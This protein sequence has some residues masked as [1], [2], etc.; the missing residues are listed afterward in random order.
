[1][2]SQHICDRQC[3]KPAIPVASVLNCRPGDGAI[4]AFFADT[5]FAIQS[6]RRTDQTK[7]MQRLHNWD[8]HLA[9]RIMD[10]RRE[11][12]KEIVNV[13]HIRTKASDGMLHQAVGV[14]GVH[15]P[16]RGFHCRCGILNAVVILLQDHHVMTVALEKRNFMASSRIFAASLLISIMKNEDFH[17]CSEIGL[18]ET[19][20]GRIRF[21]NQRFAE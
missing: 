9:A 15:T 14:P 2:R 20:K 18:C 17:L 13:D 3:G 19:M 21:S 7:V 11:A 5:S 10:G 16:D 4:Q 6:S 12:W 8:G 1:M